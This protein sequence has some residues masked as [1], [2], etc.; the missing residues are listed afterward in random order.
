MARAVIDR[1]RSLDRVLAE[2]RTG[3]TAGPD[4]A[5]ARRLVSDVLRDLPALEWRLG[6]LLKKPLPGRAREVHFLLLSAIAELR[7]GREPAHAV[8]H[9]AVEAARAVGQPGLAG[10]VNGVLRS[11]QRQ[12][13]VLD[14]GLPDD[15]ALRH[16]FPDWLVAELRRDWPGD[17][18]AILEE[19]NRPPP[20]W[21]RVNRRR[22]DPETV[23][24]ALGQAGLEAQ[25]HAHLTGALRLDRPVSMAALPGFA[26]GHVSVQDA[27]AQW[28]PELMDLADGQRVLD[29]CAAPGGKS[30]AMLERADI[31]LTAVEVDPE[32][33]EI[34]R[35][36][37]DRLGLRARLVTADAA[38][39]GA[40]WDGEGFDR[41]LIDAPCTATGVIR[42]HPDIRWLRRPADVDAAVAAQRRLLDALWPL[43]KPGGILVYAT[44]SVLAAENRGQA[45]DFL[46]RTA[47]AQVLTP[48]PE[49]GLAVEPGYQILPGA[50]G[51]D[52]FFYLV[53]RRVRES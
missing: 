1:G 47:D 51:M 9:A 32:R 49:P 40:W 33:V 17:W 29:A 16:G 46:E 25:P 38:D 41:I 7:A 11:C 39:P 37:L 27:A 28:A 12:A 23:R 35:Q 5:L 31:R 19:S 30:A 45:A 6:G 18:E 13:A 24:A 10:L 15:P 50:G 3:L 20:T 42:R 14:A 43:L 44:C 2:Y 22:S 36:G 21:L 34:T 4:R 8:V 26:Q 48:D 53:C 52:G